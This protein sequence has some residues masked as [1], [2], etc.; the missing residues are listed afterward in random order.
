MSKILSKGFLLAALF[1]CC[2]ILSAYLLWIFHGPLLSGLPVQMKLP[3]G[4]SKF[5]KSVD[6]VFAHYNEDVS[7]LNR[8]INE[9]LGIKALASYGKRVFIY[10]KG[11]EQVV[12]ELNRSVTLSVPHVF[13]IATLPNIGREGHTYLHHMT[14]Q[15][16]SLASHTVFL[17]ANTESFYQNVLYRLER[18]LHTSTGMLNLGLEA[19]CNCDGIDCITLDGLLLNFRDL[20]HISTGTMCRGQVVNIML[21]GQFVVSKKRILSRTKEFY[22]NLL[23]LFTEDRTD[24]TYKNIKYLTPDTQ[25]RFPFTSPQNPLVGHALERAWVFIF[26]CYTKSKMY[27]AMDT[28]DYF[29][30]EDTQCIDFLRPSPSL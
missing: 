14:S 30:L 15:F 12:A 2:V 23:S 24:S 11:G 20:Y 17:Q 26:D 18:L 22:S 9:L 4:T 21:R 25:S 29:N 1:S 7:A 10:T 13:A 28:D 6:F 16:N 8:T 3:I 27:P 5:E 19:T